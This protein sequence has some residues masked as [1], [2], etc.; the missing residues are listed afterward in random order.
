MNPQYIVVQS[1]FDWFGF[2]S[3]LIFCM[4][5]LFAFAASS[6]KPEEPEVDRDQEYLEHLRIMA[7]QR[8]LEKQ[9]MLDRIQ[10]D[11]M[12]QDYSKHGYVQ[13]TT[14]AHIQEN[15]PPPLEFGRVITQNDDEVHYE[16]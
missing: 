10:T 6:K 5:L 15:S 4:I 14:L 8:A 16:S 9:L 1:S 11:R 2:F 12:I 7:Q 13:P 3:L